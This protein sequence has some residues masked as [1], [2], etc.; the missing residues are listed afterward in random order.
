[1]AERPVVLFCSGGGPGGLNLARSLEAASPRP[2]LVVCDS[3]PFFL[4]LAR[5]DRKYLLPP[6]REQAPFLAGLQTLIARHSV[7]MLLPN[8]SQEARL[9]VTHRKDL[10]AR[11]L[12][13]SPEAF[14][15][16][17]D[18]WK[19]WQLWKGLGLPVPET[20]L[21][22]SAED[23][24]EVFMTCG[25]PVWVRGAGIPG[26][27]IGVASLPCRT[28]DQAVAWVDYWD[29]FGGMI[30][31]EYLP[32]ANLTWLSVW[33]EGRLLASQGRQRDAYVIPHVSPSGITGA[34]AISHTVCRE[35]INQLGV[36]AVLAVDPAYS[37]PAFVDF[38]CDADGRPRITEINV[39]R[40]GTTHNF[41]SAAGANFPELAMRAALGLPLPAWVKP[42]DVLPPDLY[43]IRNLDGGPVLAHKDWIADY[44]A[45]HGLEER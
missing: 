23:V 43:W 20:K 15:Y 5:G 32:G 35:D 13:P 44:A 33:V 34:P 22:E 8:N 21:L 29:G 1:M 42:F 10:A 30:A 25:R 37:G 38:K 19:A 40:F 2:E 39:G 12:L 16:G 14:E 27:G 45:Q 36:K 7:E 24:A 17:A 28:V 3:S 6:W 9:Y 4:Q 31:S 11:M 26:T 41:Y 18:K